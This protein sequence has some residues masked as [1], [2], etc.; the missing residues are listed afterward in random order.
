MACCK[1]QIGSLTM[2]TLVLLRISIGWHFLF[3]GIDK[4]NTKNFTSEGYLGQA[5]GPLA[6]YFHKLIPDWTGEQRFGKLAVPEGAKRDDADRRKAALKSATAE[7]SQPLDAYAT[8]FVAYYKLDDAAKQNV[9]RVVAVRKAAVE[10]YLA[11]QQEDI[12]TYFSDLGRLNRAKAD[13][14]HDLADR[15][16]WIWDTQT[17]LRGQ[18]KGWSDWLARNQEALQ[19]ELDAL[20]TPEQLS[21]HGGGVPRPLSYHFGMDRVV[22][23]SNLAIGVC[24]IAGLFTRLSALGGAAFLLMIVLAQPDWPGLYP[25]PPPAAGRTMFVGK[26]FIEMMALLVL[27]TTHVGRWGGLDFFIHH[28]IVRPLCGKKDSP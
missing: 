22:I 23:Y 17:R 6:D 1:T 9:E 24:L 14:A 27:A 8:S 25:P 11:E 12:E 4:L 3:A 28:L 13:P 15:E 5:K 19:T 21:Q 18:L 26:E 10:G 2:A 7:H 16:K 20:L